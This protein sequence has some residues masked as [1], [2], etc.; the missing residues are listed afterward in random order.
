MVGKA[1][2]IYVA[3]SLNVF[4]FR[5]LDGT[6]YLSHIIVK[7]HLSLKRDFQLWLSNLYKSMVTCKCQWMYMCKVILNWIC[8][9]NYIELRWSEAKLA[10]IEQ[11]SH[12]I[13]QS[14]HEILS[15]PIR[16]LYAEVDGLAKLHPHGRLLLS[17]LVPILD[18]S[19]DGTHF[20]R[21]TPFERCQKKAKC[22]LSER[23]CREFVNGHIY[24]KWCALL[25]PT[26]GT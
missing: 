17:P 12:S 26:F 22:K 8:A 19:P 7:V 23:A 9:T 3:H 21:T 13:H 11:D 6:P 5:N 15:K 4:D 25:T 2:V 14:V 1:R 10:R 18:R 24:H 20:Q 16:S